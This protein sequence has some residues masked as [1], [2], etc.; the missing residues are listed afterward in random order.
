MI[1][2]NIWLQ[3]IMVITAVIGITFLTKRIILIMKYKGDFDW[4]NTREGDKYSS[5]MNMTYLLS[6]Y[7]DL[8]LYH[9]YD[10]F[11]TPHKKLTN[12]QSDFIVS[13]LLPYQLMMNSDGSYQGVLTPR[14]LT[15]SIL[16]ERGG[17]DKIYNRWVENSPDE[18]TEYPTIGD[19]EGWKKLIMT[20]LNGNVDH[21]WYWCKQS[22][23]SNSSN[24]S[25]LWVPTHNSSWGK[26]PDSSGHTDLNSNCMDQNTETAMCECGT[27]TKKCED[28][29]DAVVNT[30][31]MYNSWFAEYYTDGAFGP[32]SV[33][34]PDNIFARMN[35]RPN[36][37]LIVYFVN[38]LWTAGGT[39]VDANAFK[40]AVGVGN[41]IVTGGW[42]GML[43]G[44]GDLKSSDDYAN[45]IWTT[46]ESN[47]V[48]PIDYTVCETDTAGGWFGGL[49]GLLSGVAIATM[50]LS[51][52]A[53]V[54]PIL[55][56]AAVIG[57]S[58]ALGAVQGAQP[59]C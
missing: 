34:R 7:S 16:P 49:G 35:I 45:Y 23:G 54:G 26:C 11:T 19:T 10:T 47:Y 9:I 50:F 43:Q 51:G 22:A 56:S 38:N 24:A 4:W 32:E 59:K 44:M 20:W 46:V 36:D 13:N 33:G 40:R 14:S 5:K 39:Y 31:D 53:T 25:N 8:F 12:A 28:G 15:M 58:T 21:G 30:D 41:E 37:P 27:N 18:F 6:G 1:K 29:Q 48:N 55:M 2:V 42:L 3:L 57:G 17:S 52:G